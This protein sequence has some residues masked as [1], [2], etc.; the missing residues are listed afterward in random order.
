MKNVLFAASR[1]LPASEIPFQDRGF[2]RMYSFWDNEAIDDVTERFVR[3]PQ[4]GGVVPG[5]IVAGGLTSTG[6]VDPMEDSEGVAILADKPFCIQATIRITAMPAVG[7]AAVL[8]G[9]YG[10]DT[11]AK[12]WA[13]LLNSNGSVQ[14]TITNSPGATLGGTAGKVKVNTNYHLAIERGANNVI[15]LYIDGK[16]ESTLTSTAGSAATNGRVVVRKETR[17]AIW[18][19]SIADQAVYN[20]PFTPPAKATYQNYVP[21]YSAAVAADIVAQFG[22]RRDDPHNEVNGQPFAMGGAAGLLYGNLRT[23]TTAVDTF[24]TPIDYFGAADFTYEFKFRIPSLPSSGSMGLFGQSGRHEIQVIADGRLMYN[25]TYGSSFSVRSSPVGSIVANKTYHMVVERVGTVVKLYINGV[26]MDTS[27]NGLALGHPTGNVLT[28]ITGSSLTRYIWDIRIAK[29]AMYRGVVVTPA[30]LPKM[31]V[32][33]KAAVARRSLRVGSLNTTQGLC[34]GFAK[35]FLFAGTSLS[36]G[37]LY[38]Q[39]YW[40]TT[41]NRMIRIKALIS[42]GTDR[43]CLVT[44][45]SNEPRGPN[46]PT[47]TNRIR[48]AGADFDMTSISATPTKAND[49]DNAV[50]YAYNLAAAWNGD[51]TT[52]MLQ[53]V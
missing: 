15:T 38:P 48:L 46:T 24:S 13:I 12:S 45:P 7:R 26:L 5:Q 27:T 42:I 3:Q 52:T 19:M 30:V 39:V 35:N 31:P 51:E 36:I 37:E 6:V 23:G 34:Q 47:C 21:T 33:Y 43:M 49:N 20:G 2:A 32:D 22:F 44:A 14:F 10:I 41:Q 8:F 53:F 29:R 4:S 18:D 16:A 9:V 25:F 17:G 1:N 11:A 40:N 50:Y 28:Q